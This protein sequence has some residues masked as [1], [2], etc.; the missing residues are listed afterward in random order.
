MAS[1]MKE[2][3]RIAM[4]LKR[5]GWVHEICDIPLQDCRERADWCRATFGGMYGFWN[6][7]TYSGEGKWYGS[8]LDFQTG[9]VQSN[10]QFVFMFRDDKLYTMYKMMFPE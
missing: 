5:E 8:E 10:R 2:E 4:Q 7:L 9:G 1:V 6:H 3:M